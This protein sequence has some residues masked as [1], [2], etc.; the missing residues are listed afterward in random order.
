LDEQNKERKAEK[1]TVSIRTELRTPNP[2]TEGRILTLTGRTGKSEV[3][4]QGHFA[5]SAREDYRAAVHQ[6]A[7]RSHVASA[8]WRRAPP[9]GSV[10]A[11]K[12][13]RGGAAFPPPAAAAMAAALRRSAQEKRGRKK[14]RGVVVGLAPGLQL[15]ATADGHRSRRRCRMQEKGGGGESKNGLGFGECRPAPGF[16]PGKTTVSRRMESDG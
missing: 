12:R 15:L 1:G 8:R 14:I 9:R 2:N 6:R 5:A 10:H 7:G 11:S 4:Y 13:L 16:D 3:A